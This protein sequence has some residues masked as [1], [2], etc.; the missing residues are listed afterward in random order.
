MQNVEL[1]VSTIPFYMRQQEMTS[2]LQ[3]NQTWMAIIPNISFIYS[4]NPAAPSN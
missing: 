1:E 3:I 2:F 4:N